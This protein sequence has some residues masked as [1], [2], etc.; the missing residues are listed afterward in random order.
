[1]DQAKRERLANA[2]WQFGDAEHLLGLSDREL[3]M[4]VALELR[5]LREAV[6][7]AGAERPLL[8]TAK[9]AARLLGVSRSTLYRLVAEKVL[10]KPAKNLGGSRWRRA[11][12]EQVAARLR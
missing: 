12:L 4:G 10:P 3:S 5:R 7:R 9:A 1:M 8:V 11:D 6:E 2:G